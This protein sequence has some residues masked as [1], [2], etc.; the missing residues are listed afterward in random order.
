MSCMPMPRDVCCVI[1][2]GLERPMMPRVNRW[3]QKSLI[4]WPLLCAST[5]MAHPMGNFSIN[6]YAGI[7]L[8]PRKIVVRYIMDMAEIPTFQ[9]MQEFNF[10]ALSDDARRLAYQIR[11]SKQLGAKLELAL[12]GLPILLKCDRG[13]M[14]ITPGAGG[15]PTMK[16]A[17]TCMAS[18]P[19]SSGRHTIHYLDGNFSSRAGWKEIVLNAEPNVTVEGSG[20]HPDR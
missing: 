9:E 3:F 20:T 1:Q 18:L 13:E 8:E 19:M 14:M 12:D 15:L 2:K 11:K 6:R 17:I 5:L 10:D 7:G 4:L 16:I